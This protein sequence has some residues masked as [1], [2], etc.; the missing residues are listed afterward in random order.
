MHGY[1]KCSCKKLQDIWRD[2]GELQKHCNLPHLQLDILFSAHFSAHR[3]LL[4]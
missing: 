4:L 1:A 2:E 3:L